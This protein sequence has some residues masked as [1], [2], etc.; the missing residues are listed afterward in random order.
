[1]EQQGGEAVTFQVNGRFDEASLDEL[2]QSIHAAQH[3]HKQVVI[4]L[5]EVT[6]VDRKAV[7]YLSEKTHGGVRLINCPVYLSK[8]IEGVVK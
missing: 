1:M 5:S 8:W 3:L 7:A 6:L 4:D 2:D